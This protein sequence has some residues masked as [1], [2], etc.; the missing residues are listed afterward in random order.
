MTIGFDIDNTMTNTKEQANFYYKDYEFKEDGDS[1]T[2]MPEEKRRKFLDKYVLE[3]S[4]NAS[5]KEGVKEVFD[6]LNS[7][8]HKIVLI[9]KRGFEEPA[10]LHDITVKYLAEHKLKYDKLFLAIDEKGPLAKEE[11]I[12]HFFDDHLFNLDS[13]DECGVK[14]VLYGYK[15]RNTKY[16]SVQSWSELLEYIKKEGF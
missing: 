1:Y 15:E 7:K 8:G 4:E 10:E 16:D 3:I 2:K 13:V 12:T 6:Y 5:L 14:G 9:T 11:G